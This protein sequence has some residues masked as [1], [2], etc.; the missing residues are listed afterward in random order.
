[1]LYVRYSDI[2][3]YVER[4]NYCDVGAN[5]RWILYKAVHDLTIESFVYHTSNVTHWT[6][7]ENET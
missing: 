5:F 1:M 7:G 6:K 2:K 4:Y 3:I